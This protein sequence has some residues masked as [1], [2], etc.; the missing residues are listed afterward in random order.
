MCDGFT[1]WNSKSHA[2]VGCCMTFLGTEN[3]TNAYKFDRS[4]YEQTHGP[5]VTNQLQEEKRSRA[6]MATALNIGDWVL[7]IVRWKISQFGW[8]G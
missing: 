8:V 1:E 2:I 7:L 6:E 5:N 4:H 3:E